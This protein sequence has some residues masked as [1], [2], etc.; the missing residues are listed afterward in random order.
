M[1]NH[2]TRKR[3][4]A[5]RRRAQRR[6]MARLSFVLLIAMVMARTLLMTL[7]WLGIALADILGAHIFAALYTCLFVLFGW[8]L[9]GWIEHSKRKE[10]SKCKNTQPAPAL[11]V[12]QFQATPK[13]KPA[14]LR[15][16]EP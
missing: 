5:K 15:R 4:S 16:A 7:D 11:S 2:T 13:E 12:L 3:P 14:P 10:K 8:K 1:T 6:M 9:R